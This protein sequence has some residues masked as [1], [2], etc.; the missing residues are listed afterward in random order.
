MTILRIVT[1]PLC[2]VSIYIKVCT[3]VVLVDSSEWNIGCVAPSIVSSS[4]S[5]VVRVQTRCYLSGVLLSCNRSYRLTPLIPKGFRFSREH[6]LDR[7]VAV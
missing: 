3:T 1:I 5:V 7:Y 2:L 4:N 6:L